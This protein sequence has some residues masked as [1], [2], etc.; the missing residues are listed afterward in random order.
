MILTK[1]ACF[2]TIRVSQDALKIEAKSLYLILATFVLNVF[3]LAHHVFNNIGKNL[4]RKAP[5]QWHPVAIITSNG[6]HVF[7]DMHSFSGV[8]R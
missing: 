7:S 1:D 8:Y 6:K 3:L 2:L 5:H 4:Y